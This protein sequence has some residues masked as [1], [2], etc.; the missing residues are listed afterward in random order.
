[1]ARLVS[2]AVDEI[3]ILPTLRIKLRIS[4]R[5]TIFC[6]KSLDGNSV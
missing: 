5:F 1:M 3:N 6:C 2:K 4:K